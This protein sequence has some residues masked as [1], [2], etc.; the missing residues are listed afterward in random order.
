MGQGH[1]VSPDRCV[2][3]AT[4]QPCS[5]AAYA[6]PVSPGLPDPVRAVMAQTLMLIQSPPPPLV[7]LRAV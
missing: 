2:T 4:T 5:V 3:Q 1:A 6:H 7:K